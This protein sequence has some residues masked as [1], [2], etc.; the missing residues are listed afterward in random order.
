MVKKGEKRGEHLKPHKAMALKQ[1]EIPCRHQDFLSLV[2]QN[3]KKCGSP[4]GYE[5]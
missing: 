1:S 4:L 3:S 5:L 2:I